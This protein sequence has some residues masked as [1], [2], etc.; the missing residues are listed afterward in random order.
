MTVC[1]DE[2]C[3]A[4]TSVITPLGRISTMDEPALRKFMG[5]GKCSVSG[6]NCPAFTGNADLCGNC[7]HN[8]AAHW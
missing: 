2:V 5:F 6:C 1:E 4:S 8:Y 7:G 3:S